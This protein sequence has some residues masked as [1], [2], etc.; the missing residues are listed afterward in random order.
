MRKSTQI[1]DE[2]ANIVVIAFEMESQG[3]LDDLENEAGLQ[4]A[5]TFIKVLVQTP[6]ATTSV[7]VRFSPNIADSI[8]GLAQKPALGLGFVA[9]PKQK[10]PG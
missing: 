3:S 6:D 9:Q 1:F 5:A 7:K 10:A 2:A 8:D 4:A